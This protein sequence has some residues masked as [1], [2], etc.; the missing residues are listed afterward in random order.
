MQHVSAQ[1]GLHQTKCY[2]GNLPH[3]VSWVKI[4]TQLFLS[5]THGL[6]LFETF[7]FRPSGA[8]LV[9]RDF[10]C[11]P[12]FVSVMSLFPLLLRIPLMYDP[13]QLWFSLRCIYKVQLTYLTE[14]LLFKFLF[15]DFI[16]DFVLKICSKVWE[17]INTLLDMYYI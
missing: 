3:W 6:C 12:M 11:G 2:L 8:A 10:G 14:Y 16:I 5:F 4:L 13:L 9:L 17:W 15:P 7:L 1:F